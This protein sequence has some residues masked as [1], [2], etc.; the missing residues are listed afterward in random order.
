M[1]ERMENLKQKCR[2]ERSNL[3]HYSFNLRSFIYLLISTFSD[4]DCTGVVYKA[5]DYYG[6]I[7]ARYIQSSSGFEEVKEKYLKGDYGICPRH[8]CDGQHCLP[9]GLLLF[10]LVIPLELIFYLYR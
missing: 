9:F 1:T 4:Y 10:Y 3:K 6:L 5:I 8:Y 7:H 2:F